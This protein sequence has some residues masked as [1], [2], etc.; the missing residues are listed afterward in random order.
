MCTSKIVFNLIYCYNLKFKQFLILLLSFYL[1][2]KKNTNCFHIIIYIHIYYYSNYRST[3]PF[4]VN[5]LFVYICVY[6]YRTKMA[7]AS[8]EDNFKTIFVF[9]YTYFRK[10]FTIT[11]DNLYRS[12]LPL[13]RLKILDPR[14]K[15]W[16][17]NT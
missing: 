5:R 15:R 10:M 11:L 3:V 17:P 8:S 14:P 13:P 6:D 4:I 7:V 16:T 9:V 2:K 12:P 1:Q